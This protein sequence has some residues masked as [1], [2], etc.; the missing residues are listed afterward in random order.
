MATGKFAASCC[1]SWARKQPAASPCAQ[2]CSNRQMRAA[3][4][5]SMAHL[6]FV[7][8][9]QP[10]C[11]VLGPCPWGA[12]WLEQALAGSS[13]RGSVDRDWP[14]AD[15][16]CQWHCHPSLTHNPL[17]IEVVVASQGLVHS[18]CLPKTPVFSCQAFRLSQV[19]I[20]VA[21]R[22]LAG[23]RFTP[24]WYELSGSRG[25]SSESLSHASLA[26]LQEPFKRRAGFV[27]YRRA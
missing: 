4:A 22:R 14:H 21:K 2:P 15:S 19:P 5:S 8:P 10:C 6:V 11:C 3:T 9:G 20:K 7:W 24:S 13:L 17:R 27:Q 23:D 18:S 25:C 16:N 26:S 1:C 12:Q